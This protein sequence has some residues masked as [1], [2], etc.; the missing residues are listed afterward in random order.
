MKHESENKKK[1]SSQT[2]KVITRFAPSPT[3]LLH[4]GSAR[5][6]LFNFLFT[7]QHNGKMIL[8]IE[9]TDTARSKK[10]FE[11]NILEGLA[12]LGI[13]HDELFRQS[14][15]I[16]IYKTKLEQ[17][18]K[19]G[20]AYISKETP[21]E[22]GD[23][24]E[25]I[26]LKNPGKKIRF[27]DLVRGDIE[28][29]TKE[30]GDF[31]LA[32]S[33]NEPI[34]HF[35]NVVDDILMAVTHIIRGE[36]HISNT[37]RQILIFEA[38]E[39]KLPIYAHIPLILAPDR[40]KLSKRHGAVAL[41]EYRRLGYLSEALVNYLALLG[42]NPGTPEEIFSLDQLTEKFDIAKIQK[43]GAI[44]DIRKLDWVN[45]EHIRSLSDESFLK[46]VAEW[47]KPEYTDVSMIKRIAP[48]I[49][50]RLEKF[51]DVSLMK[52]NG[53]FE[54]YF[55]EPQY[56]KEKLYWKKSAD[57]K[58]TADHLSHVLKILESLQEAKFEA[59]SIKELLWPYAEKVGRG[60]VLWPMRY[61]LS[62][63][64][65]SPDPFT[66]AAILGKSV[67]LAR[68]KYALKKFS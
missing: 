43:G 40:S 3:G 68:I 67:T 62:G 39:A 27:N 19:T 37:P 49:R 56:E 66:L 51:S 33:L 48:Q 52:K 22:E 64:D 46:L 38:L 36:D 60:E 42:W 63:K 5:S 54:Y 29:D 18:I 34:F 25:V 44:F 8:R 15:R 12:W 53:E 11:N 14:E 28:F 23:R 58:K 50:S 7:R 4:I 1:I 9:D 30:L 16:E 17:L 21:K 10:D 24:T 13:V 47:L 41:T 61:A 35:A 20:K 45:R 59:S 2:S 55:T 6:A 32:K 31:V 57:F 26:R 65:A